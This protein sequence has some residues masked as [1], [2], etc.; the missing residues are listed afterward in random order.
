MF[1]AWHEVSPGDD[2]PQEFQAVIEI[3]L[4]EREI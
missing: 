3:P 2:V 1:H 4:L